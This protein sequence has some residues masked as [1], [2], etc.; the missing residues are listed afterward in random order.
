MTLQEAHDILH[1]DTSEEV[2]TKIKYYGGF[3]GEQKALN[4]VNQ[5]CLIV[6]EC[7]KQVQQ[8]EDDWK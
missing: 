8:M 5:A 4:A 2:I 6:C 3:N 1:P 7:I